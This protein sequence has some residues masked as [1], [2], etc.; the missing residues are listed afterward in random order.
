MLGRL[1]GCARQLDVTMDTETR[2][3]AYMDAFLRGDHDFRNVGGI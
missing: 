1:M 3:T 2:V